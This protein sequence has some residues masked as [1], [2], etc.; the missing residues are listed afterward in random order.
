MG[1]DQLFGHLVHGR[2][3]SG[4]RAGAVDGYIASRRSLW[5]ELHRGPDGCFT[6]NE[7]TPFVQEAFRMRGPRRLLESASIG[8]R[9]ALAA[10]PSVNHQ[11][12]QTL[13]IKAAHSW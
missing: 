4:H 1:G 9:M 13:A 3:R 10:K 2:S 8:I 5:R 11:D 12:L 7:D 6:P